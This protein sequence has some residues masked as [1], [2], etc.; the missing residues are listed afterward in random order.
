VITPRGPNQFLL[1]GMAN[2]FVDTIQVTVLAGGERINVIPAAASARLDI[3]LLPDTDGAAFLAE[4]REAL[5]KDCDVRVLVTAPPSAPSP[6]SGRLYAALQ[7]VLGAEAPVAPTFVAGFTDSR[8]FRERRI[9]AYGLSPFALS[10][11]DV[12]GI[13]GPDE[14]VPLAELERGAARMRRILA[15]YAAAP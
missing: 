5:G 11:E 7:K 8:Y 9:P 14:H 6:A 1:P 10:S 12:R 15:R 3:R 4:V 13:H 2:L